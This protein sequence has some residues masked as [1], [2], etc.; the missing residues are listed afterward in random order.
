MKGRVCATGACVS[1]QNNNKNSCRGNI[2]QTFHRIVRGEQANEQMSCLKAARLHCRWF[3]WP[4]E[5]NLS[6]PRDKSQT[7]ARTKLQTKDRLPDD[8]RF[9]VIVFVYLTRSNSTTTFSLSP[10]PSPSSV[11]AVNGSHGV[12]ARGVGGGG[13]DRDRETGRE[14]EREGGKEKVR[15]TRPSH[16]KYSVCFYTLF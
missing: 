15:W 12:C 8:W 1:R 3:D 10:L 4:G 7:E 14:G 16:R 2:P 11:S 5:S 9:G 6:S 13:G